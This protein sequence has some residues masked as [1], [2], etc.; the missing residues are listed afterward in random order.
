MLPGGSPELTYSGRFSHVVSRAKRLFDW[1]ALEGTEWNTQEE[2]EAVIFFAIVAP[3]AAASLSGWAIFYLAYDAATYWPAAAACAI[4][5]SGLLLPFVAR[6]SRFAAEI[7]LSLIICVLFSAMV[8]MFGADSGL[9]LG[10]LVAS[11]LLVLEC[12]TKRLVILAICLSPMLFLFGALPIWFREPGLFTNASPELLNLIYMSNVGNLIAIVLICILIILRRAERAED[13]LVKEF[14]RS[15]TL[16]ANLLPA[17]IA[18]RLKRSPG[19]VIADEIPA[20]TILF[21]DIVGFTPRAATMRPEALVSFL[22]RIFSTFDELTTKHGLEKIK[23]IGDAYMVA[24]GM[25]VTRSDHAHAVADMALDM[26]AATDKLSTE[27]GDEIELRIGLHTG[28]VVAGVIGSN[29]V[30]YD[31]WGDTVN[32]SARLESH[33]ASGRIQVTA[34]TRD[35]LGSEFEFDQRG[36]IEIKG[37]GLTETFWLTDR[38]AP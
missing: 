3:I 34:A 19:E 25:P 18:A 5:N 1:Y 32:T 11:L 27:L 20:V 4:S 37:V 6:R 2:R 21:A 31:V 17:E 7:S 38:K 33:G 36:S 12:G 13:A 9:N 8:Y 15:E 26:L 14:G 30:F 35:A 29:K 16:L 10:L 28:P 23:T 24:G 22:N